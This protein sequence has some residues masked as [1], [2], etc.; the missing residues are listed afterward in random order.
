MDGSANTAA[1]FEPG[2]L[3]GPVLLPGDK[4]ITHRALIFGALCAGGVRVERPNRGADVLA[5]RDALAALGAT[6]VDD[7]EAIIVT[8]G[9]LH[10]PA[11]PLDARNSGTTARLLMGMCAGQG[12]AAH[13][14]GDVSLRRRPMDRVARPLRALGAEVVTR[15]ATLPAFVRG[16]A[17]PASVTIDLEI[18][19][20]Q[21]KSAILLAALRATGT[22][23][24]R[25]DAESRD[26]TERMLRHFGRDVVWDGSEVTLRPGA[27]RAAGVRV[28]ADLSAAAFFLTAAAVVPGGDVIVPGVGVNPTRTGVLDALRAM[29]ADLTLSREHDRDGE[30]VADVRVRY[31]PLRAIEIR[32]MLVVRAI[33][34]LPVLAVAAAFAHG[35]T[36]IR[37]AAELRAK[38]S[39]RIAVVAA[40]LRAFGVDAQELP[41]GIDVRGGVPRAPAEA[42]ATHG[43]HRIAMAAAVLAAATGAVTVDD[44]RCTEISFPGFA[45]AW[46]SAQRNA[47]AS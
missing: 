24:V 23:C 13:F 41:D 10:D 35:V 19:S 40:M 28:P 30:P 45:A 9:A 11:A 27:L 42:V 26:H 15:D 25:G 33:D 6:T 46:R 16:G 21:V 20:A 38:E 29:G 14:D 36:R 18:P 2:A 47:I 22:V 8:G 37:D 44:A 12:L 1:R 7:G 39:D 31:A 3:R 43:D 34:E 17:P 32:G 4:S 5:T